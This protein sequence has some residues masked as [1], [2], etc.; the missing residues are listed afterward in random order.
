MADDLAVG[1]FTAAKAQHE[2]SAKWHLIVLAVLAYFHLALAG[3]F[4]EQS[5]EL[6]VI[7]HERDQKRAFEEQLQDALVRASEF[8]NFVQAEIA[9]TSSALRGELVGAFATLDAIIPQLIALGPERAGGDEGARLFQLS[10]M[11]GTQQQQQQQQQ[12]APPQPETL[13][14]T[15]AVME[16]AL[17]ARLAEVAK[18]SNGDLRQ[19]AEL[20][21]YI[22]DFIVAPAIRN[23]N[24]AWATDL[25]TIESMAGELDERLR[26]AIGTAGSAADQLNGLREAVSKLVKNAQELKFAAPSDTAWWS[27]I[28]GKDVSIQRML[29][30]MT[31]S[32]NQRRNA[33][34]AVES[35]AAQAARAIEESDQRAEEVTAELAKLEEQA[36]ELQT[37]LG[38]I[39]EP[40]KVI[41]I[42]LSVLAPLLPLVIALTIA[43]LSLWRAEG[44]RRM[45]FAAALVPSGAEGDLLRR[46]LQEAAGGSARV[47]AAREIAIAG[48]ALAWV[49]AAQRAVHA[50]PAPQLSAFEII[51]LALAALIGARAYHWYQSGQALGFATRR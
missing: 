48:V 43:A 49:S 42:R 17:R 46:W 39:G 19:V 24:E 3:P 23:A 9:N 31:E 41:S 16:P 18:S 47:L 20:T 44:I 38:T 11:S 10:A 22:S 7:L 37:Q 33:L 12:Q 29:E 51:G 30:A 28:A 8:T 35:Q 34:K 26:S 32:I 40:L 50:L 15:L 27:T 45:R 36:R 2:A 13:T 5:Q 21:S 25:Q 1:F 6:A 4:A 14:P